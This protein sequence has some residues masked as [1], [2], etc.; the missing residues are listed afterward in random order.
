MTT[1][2]SRKQ[3]SKPQSISEWLSNH[4]F[5][6]FLFVY[7]IWVF[8]PFLAPFFMQIGWAAAG[9]AI[10]FVYSFFCHQ[11]PERSL[12]FFGEKSMY[13]LT[14]IQAAWQ[15]TTNPII[16]RQFTGNESMGWKVA[17][18]DRMTSFY[19]SVWFFALVWF[20]LRRRV[21]PLPWW[22]LLLMLLPITLD[23]AT[24]TLSDLAGIGQGFRDTNEWL[25]VLTNHS[26]PASFYAGDALGSFNSLM[27]FST[28]LL[29][30]LGIVWLTLPCIFQTQAYNQEVDKI[31]YAKAIEQ[32]P[33]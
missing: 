27:R 4:W 17:W 6:V 13:S 32:V 33:R 28:G 22:G 18:S 16:L 11:L 12:F 26:F 30:G 21:K 2:V 23:G 24:H 14:E 31:S 1:I 9:K 15:N 8:L 3:I 29:A 7:G 19:T 10:Y 20:P 5:G 25:V